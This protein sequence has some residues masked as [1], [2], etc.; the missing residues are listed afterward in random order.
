MNLEQ[1]KNHYYVNF[2]KRGYTSEDGIET[3]TIGS[4]SKRLMLDPKSVHDLLAN[5]VLTPITA[6]EDGSRLGF[7]AEHLDECRR[8]VVDQTC[9][10][11]EE[12]AGSSGNLSAVAHALV[13]LQ[14]RSNFAVKKHQELVRFNR[15]ASIRPDIEFGLITDGA[16]MLAKRFLGGA[17]ADVIG[18]GIKGA[19][20]GG[21]T[22]ALGNAAGAAIHN[23]TDSNPNDHE[24]I[25][26]AGLRGATGGALVG[27]VGGV[28]GSIFKNGWPSGPGPSIGRSGSTP[29][30]PTDPVAAAKQANASVVSKP[31][32]TNGDQ[33]DQPYWKR[34]QGNQL[35]SRFPLVRFASL[36]SRIKNGGINAEEVPSGVETTQR[37]PGVAESAQGD[38]DP[39]D[40]WMTEKAIRAWHSCKKTA[41]PVRRAV[42]I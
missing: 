9:A 33:G 4:L 35:F 30:L 34:N 13:Q 39:E 10:D 22:G 40:P 11:S 42:S 24:S 8:H 36:R 1:L 14:R 21:V 32:L 19:L 23:A 25:V 29:A 20:I 18:S 12:G 37:L 27:G 17:G 31:Q 2:D 28:A 16:G 26:G 41:L 38:V 6:S 15:I 3:H 5:G 7:H